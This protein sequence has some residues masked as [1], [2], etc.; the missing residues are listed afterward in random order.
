MLWDWAESHFLLFSV[1]L[2]DTVIAYPLWSVVDAE[3]DPSRGWSSW[4]VNCDVIHWETR[5]LSSD[6]KHMELGAKGD[7][8]KKKCRDDGQIVMLE[9]T[10]ILWQQTHASFTNIL[11]KFSSNKG[12]NVQIYWYI[13]WGDNGDSDTARQV[14]GAGMDNM[15]LSFK[16]PLCK[17]E[18]CTDNGFWR[19]QRRESR[20]Y[21]YLLRPRN[22]WN[23]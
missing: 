15:T 21:Q 14:L 4:R 3:G 5:Q 11:P 23:S 8:K 12:F 18:H 2:R 22:A 9:N 17:D 16:Y 7:K 10:V 13:F 6:F 19:G 20:T 1:F